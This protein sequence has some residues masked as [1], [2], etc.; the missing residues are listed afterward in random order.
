MNKNY[1]LSPLDALVVAEVKRL[2]AAELS[3]ASAY[4]KLSPED[5]V[6]ELSF[7]SSLADVNE[8]ASRLERLLDAMDGCGFRMGASEPMML[9]SAA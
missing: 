6:S 1:E 2:R 5:Q 9:P 8:R 3:L 7:L 4:S